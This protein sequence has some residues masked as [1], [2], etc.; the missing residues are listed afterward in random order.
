MI[1]GGQPL[2]L[3]VVGGGCKKSCPPSISIPPCPRLTNTWPASG[4]KPTSRRKCWPGC[5]LSTPGCGVNGGLLEHTSRAARIPPFPWCSVGRANLIATVTSTVAALG[6]LRIRPTQV[7]PC[8][9]QSQL[10]IC[11]ELLIYCAC[12]VCASEQAQSS[13]DQISPETAG[14]AASKSRT[15]FRQSGPIVLR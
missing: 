10:S 15:I 6:T 1:Q 2:S 3:L 5:S 11:E 8:L 13:A 14:V 7:R 9:G 12:L 4:K